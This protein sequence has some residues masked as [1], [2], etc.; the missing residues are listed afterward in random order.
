MDAR[1]RDMDVKLEDPRDIARTWHDQRISFE[2]PGY[3]RFAVTADRRTTAPQDAAAPPGARPRRSA[4]EVDADVVHVVAAERARAE[5]ALPGDV[6]IIPA[7]GPVIP[8]S[9]PVVPFVDEL[10]DG[11]ILAIGAPDEAPAE[12]GA[13][14]PRLGRHDRKW[15]RI[16]WVLDEISGERFLTGIGALM[17][18]DRT[19]FE[20][21]V[22]LAHAPSADV[23][24]DAAQRGRELRDRA[25]SAARACGQ[26]AVLHVHDGL[27]DVV[28]TGLDPRVPPLRSEPAR[29]TRSPGMCPLTG[30][31]ENLPCRAEGGPSSEDDVRA[32]LAFDGRR[33]LAVALLGCGVCHGRRRDDDGKGGAVP[34][35]LPLTLPLGQ[36][37]RITV[38]TGE[39]VEI[40][41]LEDIYQFEEPF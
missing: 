4:E 32:R 30:D 23:S 20:P 9:T 33:S 13:E 28:P 41:A 5:V 24:P 7:L 12:D 36:I 10:E 37:P 39:T 29:I 1:G 14:S 35:P 40:D 6:V 17:A 38:R 11:S 2:L 27:L 34:V 3:G 26:V 31:D 21:A 16:Q 18:E 19:W 22:A 8:T 25:L 15:L